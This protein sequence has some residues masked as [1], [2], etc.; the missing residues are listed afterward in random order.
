M[1]SILGLCSLGFTL[2]CCGAALA[3]PVDD[4]ASPVYRDVFLDCKNRGN[5]NLLDF[6]RHQPCYRHGQRRAPDAS[7]IR[8]PRRREPDGMCTIRST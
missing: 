5:D 1:R 8:L 4:H 6:Y 2:A 3:A 7:R